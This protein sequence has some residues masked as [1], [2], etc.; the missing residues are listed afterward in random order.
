MGRKV[1][2]FQ[3][4]QTA[5]QKWDVGDYVGMDQSGTRA[6]YEVSAARGASGGAAVD[7]NGDLFALHNAE[8]SPDPPKP[9][10]KQNQGVRI[11]LVAKDFG[12]ARPGFWLPVPAVDESRLFW[13]LNAD[14]RTGRI[15][16]DG[17]GH[18]APP[19]IWPGC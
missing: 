4:P 6:R 9:A 15:P 10:K 1:M 8:V 19:R 3:H 17:F 5:P 11:D 16:P 2:V 18:D 14:H 12:S 7:A 13:S